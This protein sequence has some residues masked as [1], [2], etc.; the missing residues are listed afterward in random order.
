MNLGLDKKPTD[1]YIVPVQFVAGLGWAGLPNPL[2]LSGDGI[3]QTWT[4]Q[5]ADHAS[6]SPCSSALCLWCCPH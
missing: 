1:Y 2:T 5:G 4:P 6:D 3:R